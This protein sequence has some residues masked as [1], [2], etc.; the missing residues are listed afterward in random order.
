MDNLWKLASTHPLVGTRLGFSD[1]RDRRETLISLL[2]QCSALISPSTYLARFHIAHGVDERLIRVRRQGVDLYECPMR[3]PSSIVRFGFLGQ[4]K[5]HKGVDL[6]LDAWRTLNSDQ[7]RHLYIYGSAEGE[8]AYGDHIRS[9]VGRMEDV[10]WLGSFRGN[11]VW[12]VLRELDVVVIPSRWVENSPNSIL[13]AQ[14]VGVAV[15][16]ANLGAVPELVQHGH[17]GLVFAID[18]AADLARQLH[19]LLDDPDLLQRLRTNQL[20]F[21]TVDDEIDELHELYLRILSADSA[22][23]GQIQGVESQIAG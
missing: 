3:I 12:D 1:Q 5:H 18:D 6:L 7:P 14:A 21:K 8:P 16:G 20:P 19:R 15:I 2:N 13:E 23:C 4:V 22:T 17:N 11:E 9:L 10:S